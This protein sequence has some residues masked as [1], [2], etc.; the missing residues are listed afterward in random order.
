MLY[1]QYSVGELGKLFWL[2]L[3]PS[4]IIDS[5]FILIASYFI[6]YFL[7]KGE[8]RRAKIQV[9]KMLGKRY[10]KIVMQ[11]AKDYITFITKKPFK[12]KNDINNIEDVKEQINDLSSN[13]Q[14]YITSNFFKENVKVL[15]FND[16]LPT[17]N[18]FDMFQEKQWTVQEYTQHMKNTHSKN[19]DLFI[20]KYI[21]VIPQ[22]LRETLFRVEDIMQGNYFVTGLDF[23]VNIDT[24]NAEFDTKE[25]SG[26]FRELGKDIYYLLTYFEGIEE[27]DASK[28]FRGGLFHNSNSETLLFI[29]LLP[30]IVYVLVKIS[31]L[32][33]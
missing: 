5:L 17:N 29:I 21:S 4:V 27:I 31:T 20:T 2:S 14:K 28:K 8:K 1:I 23:N 16:Q 32:N 22:D 12:T 9:Y 13:M 33:F 3:I 25:F 11:F 15:Y 10:E 6:A 19:L 30:M 24:S 7:Q 26:F 18:I